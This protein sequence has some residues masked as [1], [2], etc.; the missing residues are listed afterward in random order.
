MTSAIIFDL[1]GTLLNTLADLRDSVDHSLSAFGYPRRTTEE[2]RRFVG[3]GI[4]KLVER[5]APDGLNNIDYPTI[6]S[7]YE[8]QV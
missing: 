1:D 8:F 7:E 6:L 4:A 3:N 2:V 5:A